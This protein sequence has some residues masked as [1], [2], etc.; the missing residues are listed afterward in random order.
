MS[1]LSSV[2][3]GTVGSASMTAVS[4][5]S[6]LDFYCVKKQPTDIITSYCGIYPFIIGECP[7]LSLR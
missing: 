6:L 4:I 3:P 7:P 2:V 1:L 5:S